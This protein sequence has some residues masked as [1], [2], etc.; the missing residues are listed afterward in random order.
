MQVHH[1][2]FRP[3]KPDTPLTRKLARLCEIRRSL[4]DDRTRVVLK[5]TSL[6]KSFYPLA[7]DLLMGDVTCERT[8]EWLKRRPS[9]QKLKRARSGSLRRFLQKHGYRNQDQIDGIIERVRDA[10]TLTNDAAFV[11]P[12]AL[13]VEALVAQTGQLNKHIA[14]F[15]QQIRLVMSKHEDTVSRGRIPRRAPCPERPP[16]SRSAETC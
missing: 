6:L 11:D 8:L 12:S 9:H 1:R 16:S 3:W 4:V 10:N 5:L 2:Q 15:Q 14:E 7:L 13:Y